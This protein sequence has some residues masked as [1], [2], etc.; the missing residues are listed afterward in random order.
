MRKTLR[1]ILSVLVITALSVL[2]FA[3]CGQNTTF[4]IVAPDGATYA[5][6]VQM[7]HDVSEIDGNALSFSIEQE[8]LI[9]SAMT[10]GSADFIIAPTNIGNN[11]HEAWN[12]NNNLPEYKLTAAVSW[13]VLYIISTDSSLN[14]RSEFPYTAAGLD[15][16]LSQFSGKTLETIG[17][18][19]IPGK[20]AEYI[21]S[22]KNV[23]LNGVSAPSEIVSKVK[24]Q[25]TVTG[26]I[27]E[28]VLSSIRNECEVL[29]SVGGIYEE[30]SGKGFPMASLFVKAS[31]AET[32]EKA[33]NECLD[34]L[35]TSIDFF[36]DSPKQ[37]GIWA[38]EFGDSAAIK[39][40]TIEAAAA[41]MNLKFRSSE[42]SK[43]AVSALLQN[44]G[45]SVSE[46]L[47][48]K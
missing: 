8:S 33:V 41:N 39:A 38:E 42:E 14:P 6:L 17:L 21:F 16:F 43:D 30:L 11:I 27:A 28:P 1:M 5:A 32:R 31:I 10:N 3:A 7:R 2:C 15:E 44:I 12:K 29:A 9:S 46:G 47:F 22:E 26:I 20:T 37:V 13:G 34:K 18:S 45:N 23:S 40:A 48:L 25:Q 24:L 19:A 35:K 4:N 36:N